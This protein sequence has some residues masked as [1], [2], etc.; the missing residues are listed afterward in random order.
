[1]SLIT[2]HLLRAGGKALAVAGAALLLITLSYV[3]SPAGQV[4]T[5]K[6]TSCVCP[7][8]AP[9]YCANG[10]KPAAG[11]CTCNTATQFLSA[12]CTCQK[13]TGV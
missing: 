6:T 1:M 8:S 11:V 2:A 13:K 12:S 10:E 4:K 9:R 7:A 5:K 3:L